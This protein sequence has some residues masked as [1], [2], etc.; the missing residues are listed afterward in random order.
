MEATYKT[1]L[2]FKVDQK[3]TPMGLGDVTGA[4]PK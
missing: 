4:D 3:L 1:L 2:P